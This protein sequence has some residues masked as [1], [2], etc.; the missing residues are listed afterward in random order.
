MVGVHDQA[1]GEDHEGERGPVKGSRESQ[2]SDS[3][4]I[5]THIRKNQGIMTNKAGLI[6]CV[7]PA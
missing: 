6:A 7:K 3:G 4:L 2:D 1:E 5:E